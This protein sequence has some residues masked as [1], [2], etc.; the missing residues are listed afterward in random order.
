[1]CATRWR[2]ELPHHTFRD[3]RLVH[4]VGAFFA[5]AGTRVD[6]EV[7]RFWC[8]KACPALRQATPAGRLQF[9]LELIKKIRVG[10]EGRLLLYRPICDGKREQLGRERLRKSRNI[11]TVTSNH[12][13]Q[14]TFCQRMQML[15]RPSSGSTR[16]LGPLSNRFLP[17]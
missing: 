17:A 9:G 6:T 2:K 4:R 8:P 16:R 14:A 5:P 13:A 15:C 7:Q 12:R 3:F 11:G 10:R 1:M